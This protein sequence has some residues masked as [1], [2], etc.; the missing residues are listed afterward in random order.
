[1]SIEIMLKDGSLLTIRPAEACDAA[2][3]IEYAEAISSES[4]N[5]T[6][7][8]GEFGIG[9]EDEKAFVEKINGAN[10]SVY[11]VGVIAG[12]IV[13]S[14]IFSGGTRP[15]TAHTGEMSMSVLKAHWGKGIGTALIK[16][17]I[18]WAKV[19]GVVTKM[20]LNVRT[21]NR[22][23]IKLYQKAGFIEVGKTSRDLFIKGEYY[24]C[25]IMELILD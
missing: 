7:G 2:E 15:R 5:L 8:P 9:I 25:L 20:N 14:I 21:D 1:M 12:K 19:T 23:A 11:L 4:D 10:N 17:L 3:I 18:G 22:S 16:A 24:D 6:F 13:G